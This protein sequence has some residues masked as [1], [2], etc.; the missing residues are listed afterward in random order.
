MQCLES[1]RSYNSN[2][3]HFLR[4]RPAW[5]A[6]HCLDRIP[7]K[8]DKIPPSQITTVEPGVWLVQS[9]VTSPGY[10][11]RLASWRDSSIPSC[12]CI[13]WQLHCLPCKHLLAV[14][15]C[16]GT[17]CSWDSLPNFYLNIPQINIERFLDLPVPQSSEGDESTDTANSDSTVTADDV[18]DSAREV[19]E[20]TTVHDENVSVA[21]NAAKILP[22][23]SADIVN[24]ST[25]DLC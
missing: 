11:V 12:E 3:L 22:R 15:M 16:P 23:E 21:P 17:S 20:T 6:K 9:Q 2:V 14:I 5:F 7:P 19:T 25:S 24:C 13:D 10:I 18:Q 1:V 4:N 8:I